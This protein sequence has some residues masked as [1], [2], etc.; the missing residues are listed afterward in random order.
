[1]RLVMHFRGLDLAIFRVLSEK[2]VR[3]GVYL[4]F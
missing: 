3:I 4:Y 1:M 2:K